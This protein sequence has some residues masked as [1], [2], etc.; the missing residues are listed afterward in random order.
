MGI[1]R[2]GKGKFVKGSKFW[3]GKKRTELDR[4]KMSQS[5]KNRTKKVWNVGLT[6]ETD[7]RLMKISLNLKKKSS[8]SKGKTFSKEHCEKISK[9][10]KGK[11]R[12]ASTKEKIKL[13]RMHQVFPKKDTK[14]EKMMQIALSLHKI[15]FVTHKPIFGQPDIFIEPNICIFVDGDYWHNLPSSLKRDSEVNHK[16][17]E[18][19]YKVIRIWESTIKKDV[20][21]SALNIINMIK[22]E[23]LVN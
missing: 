12:S 19:G 7:E 23:V 15:K 14:P 5:A 4:K 3:L 2:D 16:L 8:W 17:N 13:A 20:N 22:N 10:N 21:N 11:I 18:M 9:S 6:K 1:I